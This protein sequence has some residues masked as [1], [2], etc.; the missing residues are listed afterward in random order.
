MTLEGFTSQI[1]KLDS[2]ESCNEYLKKHFHDIRPIFYG[3]TL[4][5]IHI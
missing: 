2:L 1:V 5:L 3:L 4:S